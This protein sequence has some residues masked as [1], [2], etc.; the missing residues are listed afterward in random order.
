MHDGKGPGIAAG[1]GHG[2][3]YALV[4]APNFWTNSR[5]STRAFVFEWARSMGRNPPLDQFSSHR[6][7]HCRKRNLH[8]FQSLR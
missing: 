8:P 2:M 3:I 6:S 7:S 4:A 5:S 1:V